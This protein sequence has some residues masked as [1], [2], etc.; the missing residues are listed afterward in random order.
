MSCGTKC[1]VVSCFSTESVA[2]LSTF[3]SRDWHLKYLSAVCLN[4][5][6]ICSRVTHGLCRL[7]IS[8]LPVIE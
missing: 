8:Q 7:F 6:I 4:V 3:V 1:F 2:G 5:V